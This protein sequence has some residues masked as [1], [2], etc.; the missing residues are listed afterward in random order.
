M[1]A[2]DQPH[3]YAVYWLTKDLDYLRLRHEPVDVE[4]VDVEPDAVRSRGRLREMKKA[5]KK[6]REDMKAHAW[7]QDDPDRSSFGYYSEPSFNNRLLFFSSTGHFGLSAGDAQVG[8]NIYLLEGARE[9]FILRE[10]DIPDE[11]MV[12]GTAQVMLRANSNWAA[13]D[14]KDYLKGLRGEPEWRDVVLV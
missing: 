11:H 5:A 6:K 9:F 7:N 3:L 8:D 2:W 13:L 10:G 4:P 12:V 14:S 1:E